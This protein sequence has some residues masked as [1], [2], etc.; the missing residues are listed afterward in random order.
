MESEPSIVV[1]KDLL[2]ETKDG[3][4]GKDQPF[5][6]SMEMAVVRGT[7]FPSVRLGDLSTAPSRHIAR[8][9][10][11]RKTLQVGDILIETAGGSKDR[12]T[13]RT[14]FI[15]QRVIERSTLPLTCASFARFLRV[16]PGLVEPEYVYWFLQALYASGAIEKHQ[17]QH[18]GIARFQYTKFAGEIGIPLLPRN[19]QVAIS[20]SLGVIDDKIALLRETNATLEAIAQAIFKSWFVDFDPVRAKAEGRDPEGVP[21]EVADLF[22]SEFEDSESGTIPKAWRDLRLDEA[23]EINPG[24]RIAK[25]TEASYLE[26]SALPTR[27]HRPA[28]PV[29]REFSSGT[30]FINGDSLLARITPCLENG[31]SAFVDFLSADEVGWGST[32]YIVLRPKHPMPAYWGYLLCRHEPFRQFAIQAMVGTSGRQRVDVSRL[33]QY[34]VNIPPEVI[35]RAFDEIVEPLREQIAANDEQAKV[36]G[37]IRDTLLP[38]LMSG[39]LETFIESAGTR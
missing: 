10:G 26:M 15:S 23:C 5:E 6:G 34:R 27:G 37:G 9:A 21:P 35:A 14:I 18:S 16:D 1:L 36:I 17:V 38:R 8:K 20:R 2:S 24:R 3:E 39:K 28:K 31:K 30:K 22:P 19:E 29:A 33:S 25:G 12:P 13:G 7:D 32:E 4:W 11:S